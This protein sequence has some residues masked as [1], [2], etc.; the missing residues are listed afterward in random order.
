MMSYI[1]LHY[2]ERSHPKTQYPQQ[3]VDYLCERFSLRLNFRSDR[4]RLSTLAGVNPVRQG[5][6]IPSVASHGAYTVTCTFIGGQIDVI[7]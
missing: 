3:L 2:N 6:A 7:D 4:A 1:K 5:T